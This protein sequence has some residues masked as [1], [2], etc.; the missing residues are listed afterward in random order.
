MEALTVAALETGPESDCSER[1]TNLIGS[2]PTQATTQVNNMFAAGVKYR[3]DIAHHCAIEDEVPAV[4]FPD[5]L[6]EVAHAEPHAPDKDKMK[7]L[8]GK[9]FRNLKR[10][11]HD[12]KK[13]KS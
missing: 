10:G 8:V 13:K 3:D 6:G 7:A 4:P 11:E 1:L 2:A 9:D 12:I 5:L